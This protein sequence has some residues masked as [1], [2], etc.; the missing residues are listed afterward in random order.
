MYNKMGYEHKYNKYKS[1]YHNLKRMVDEGINKS[2]KSSIPLNKILGSLYGNCVGD[3]LGTRYE[4][5]SAEDARESVRTDTTDDIL[6]I[7]GGGPFGTEP[8]QIS[9]DAEMTMSLLTSIAS[10]RGYNQDDVA[11]KYIYWYD[12]KPIDIGNTIKRSLATRTKSETSLDMIRNSEELNM[13]SLSNGVLMR[14][15]PLGSLATKMSSEA[16]KIIVDQE[17]DLT[18]P[19][20]IVKDAVYIYCQA[21]KYCLKGLDKQSIYQALLKRVTEPR[22][23]IILKDSQDTPVPSYLISE[24]GKEMYICPDSKKYQGYFGIALQMA[25]YELFNGKDFDSSIISI[26]KKGGDTD[27]NAA[28]AG[29][30][31]GAFYGLDSINKE[32]LKS[33]RN[34]SIS[35]VQKYPSMSPSNIEELVGKLFK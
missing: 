14:A 31:L 27:T 19:N 12:T 10:T 7:L 20:P 8:G 11:K 9:D 23:K 2:S 13:S 26:I 16:L 21:I 34:T 22:I 32:W 6:L 1:K 33:V 25:L 29:G 24:K 5:L 3:A 15:A 18:H 35:R 17:C 30:L 4:F 28:I